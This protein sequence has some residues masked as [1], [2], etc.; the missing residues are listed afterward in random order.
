VR[1][2]SATNFTIQNNIIDNCTDAPS[3]VS[4]QACG[5]HWGDPTAAQGSSA[6]I[7]LGTAL[8]Q[9]NVYIFIPPTPG[10]T[11]GGRA[12]WGNN[13]TGISFKDERIECVSNGC[14]GNTQTGPYVFAGISNKSGS[15]YFNI[16]AC[17]IAA[18]AFLTDI[19]GSGGGET[20]ASTVQTYNVIAVVSGGATQ[21]LL[22]SCP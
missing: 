20:Q 14:L 3:S 11:G 15:Q 12:H 4:W 9:H 2:R 21:N 17:S 22:G 6:T 13:A 1:P 10:G 5:V 18:T 8:V 7:N 19:V 16:T